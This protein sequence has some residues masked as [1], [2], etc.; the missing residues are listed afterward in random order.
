MQ[1]NKK[2]ALFCDVDNVAITFR[3]FEHML[4]QIKQSGQ[5]CYAKIYGINER[6]NK[7]FLTLCSEQGYEIAPTMRIKKRN[8]KVFD[9]RILIDCMET[10]LQNSNIDAVA[11]ICAPND[12]VWLYRKLKAYAVTIFAINNC[13][14]QSNSLIDNV[15]CLMGNGEVSASEEYTDTKHEIYYDEDIIDNNE[16]FSEVA[17]A[18]TLDDKE[19]EQ[20]LVFLDNADTDH[21]IM[22]DIDSITDAIDQEL[23]VKIHHLSAEKE[24]EN[25]EDHYNS[26]NNDDYILLSKID[27]VC[28][29]NKDT[30][31]E[32]ENEKLL[33]EIQRLLNEYN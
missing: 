16:D 13:D 8:Q 32:E 10:V 6:K 15:L 19:D 21:A 2:I 9:Q 20:T 14:E 30:S 7:D 33:S 11:L 5:V 24:V 29:E 4:F 23:M 12:M 31:D 1:T 22:E 26:V 18:Q 25:S 17:A 28:G 3:D 27:A